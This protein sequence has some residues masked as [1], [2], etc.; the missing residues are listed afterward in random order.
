[1]LQLRVA[2]L[3]SMYRMI[4]SPARDLLS[5]KLM[6]LAPSHPQA[7]STNY[8]MG[9]ATA[10]S[11]SIA[12]EA[13]PGLTKRSMGKINALLLSFYNFSVRYNVTLQC[14]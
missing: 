7:P 13:L 4:T 12:S 14:S 11:I 2:C 8:I 6:H 5:I 9:M 10:D 1:M 3:P